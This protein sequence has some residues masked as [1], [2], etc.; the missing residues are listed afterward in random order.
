M[1]EVLRA[2]MYFLPLYNARS[3][4]FF[5]RS[6]LY[7]LLLPSSRMSDMTIS[8]LHSYGSTCLEEYIS[9]F[10]LYH[11]PVLVKVMLCGGIMVCLP[12]GTYLFIFLL[13]YFSGDPERGHREGS[14]D[15]EQ[16]WSWQ[17]SIF[18]TKAY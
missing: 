18:F 11:L 4:N 17:G 6:D 2:A 12:R 7:R 15:D 1:V 8:S 3:F 16:S 10:S 9:N 5:V 13:L 14:W